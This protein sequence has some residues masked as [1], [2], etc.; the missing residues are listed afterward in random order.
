MTTSLKTS[1]VVDGLYCVG[2]SRIGYSN[3]LR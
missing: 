1:F 2:P 3:A